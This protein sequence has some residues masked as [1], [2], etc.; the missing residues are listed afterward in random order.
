MAAG[1]GIRVRSCSAVNS[2]AMGSGKDSTGLSGRACWLA[3][4]MKNPVLLGAKRGSSGGT[5][6]ILGG[7]SWRFRP[8][9]HPTDPG[10]FFVY[11][12][13]VLS[14]LPT[15]KRTDLEAL[16]LILAPVF[17]LRPSRALRVAILNVPKPINWTASPFLRAPAMESTTASTACSAA[18]FVVSLPS[19]F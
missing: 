7:K 13:F 17:G 15:E 4:E 2:G 12:S 10:K 6:G 16:I 8:K 1:T 19:A 18:A 9:D 14:A 11:L 3:H 5:G